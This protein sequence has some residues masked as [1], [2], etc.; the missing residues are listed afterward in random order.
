M[1]YQRQQVEYQKK[2]DEYYSNLLAQN[3]ALLSVSWSN[4]LFVTTTNTWCVPYFLN[5]DLHLICRNWHNKRASRCQ[6][7]GCCLRTLHRRHQC[8]RLHLHHNS[9]WYVH[10]CVCVTNEELNGY[11]PMC[12]CVT[13][14]WDT[15]RF[16]C[17]T[18]R[19]IWSRRRLN[20]LGEQLFQHPESSRR[21]WP[22]LQPT[23]R[24]ICVIDYVNVDVKN[25]V[26]VDFKLCECDGCGTMWMWYG[27]QSMCDYNVHVLWLLI[28]VWECV[29]EIVVYVIFWC[30]KSVIL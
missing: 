15:S 26:N 9:L 12:M 1:E 8:C 10:I 17:R 24:R 21:K 3:Q 11:Y 5:N 27:F 19:W 25:Y 30:I 23:W 6:H 7:M 14:L 13:G 16:G 28:D 18:W 22:Q 2:K 29:Y 4:I 20:F